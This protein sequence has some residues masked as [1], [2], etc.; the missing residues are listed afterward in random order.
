MAVGCCDGAGTFPPPDTVLFDGV[1]AGVLFRFT[2]V[3]LHVAFF[4]VPFTLAVIFVL[5]TFNAVTTPFFDTL[6]TFFLLLFHVIFFCVVFFGLNFA[7]SFKRFPFC[8]LYVE[9]FRTIFLSL[10]FFLRAESADIL[11]E[12]MSVNTINILR[13]H[14]NCLFAF[15]IEILSILKR[16]YRRLV[17]AS[18]CDA[19]SQKETFL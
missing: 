3:I 11:G 6:A 16:L 4:F 1:C 15:F 12:K 2:T 9:W 7:F 14:A 13:N 5:P 10:T 18:F 8:N 19:P 17:F